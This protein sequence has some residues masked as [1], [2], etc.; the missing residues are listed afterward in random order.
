MA[1]AMEREQTTSRSLLMVAGAA[2]TGPEPML[3]R[4]VRGCIVLAFTASVAAVVPC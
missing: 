2:V 1:L 3:G 4:L